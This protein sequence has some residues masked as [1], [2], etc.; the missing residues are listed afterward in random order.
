MNRI[1]VFAI[2]FTLFI[3]L[4]SYAQY[5]SS[6][7]TPKKAGDLIESTSYND[8]K[9]ELPVCCNTCRPVKSLSASTART[10]THVLCMANIR[11]GAWKPAT[12]RYLPRM[13]RTT[14]V[15]S[16]FACICRTGTVTPLEET[17]WCEARYNPGT[18]TVCLERQGMGRKLQPESFRIGKSYG[19]DG[20]LGA[21][22]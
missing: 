4:G 9:R 15:I 1:S 12:V 17:D 2:I 10:A 16:V 3:P 19:R 21:F 6:S 5:A 11:H 7:K 22:R 14:A 13:S 8:H 18:R 20:R